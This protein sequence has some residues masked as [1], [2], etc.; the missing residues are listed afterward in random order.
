MGGVSQPSPVTNSSPDQL[1]SQSLQRPA[2]AGIFRRSPEDLQASGLRVQLGEIGKPLLT[3][4]PLPPFHSSHRRARRCRAT[5]S[6]SL[7]NRFICRRTRDPGRE[8]KSGVNSQFR[9]DWCRFSPNGRNLNVI[10]KRT[11]MYDSHFSL[12]RLVLRYGVQQRLPGAPV[13]C[14]VR[15][16]PHERDDIRED[17]SRARLRH[18]TDRYVASVLEAYE[19]RCFS[20]AISRTRKVFP[21]DRKVHAGVTLLPGRAGHAV[22]GEGSPASRHGRHFTQFSDTARGEKKRKRKLFS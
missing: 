3:T 6:F 13:G 11:A 12:K 8:A 19:R 14:G 17:T 10:V 1:G 21:R 20:V 16:S 7:M 18:W 9:F 2:G 22:D 15:R 4:R 5:F